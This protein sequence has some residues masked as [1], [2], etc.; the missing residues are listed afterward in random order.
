METLTSLEM[1]GKS[2]LAVNLHTCNRLFPLPQEPAVGNPQPC[3]P[4]FDKGSPQEHC[5]L[6]CGCRA[7]FRSHLFLM[8]N[9][10]RLAQ[11]SRTI[12]AHLFPASPQVCPQM[13]TSQ[14]CLA[15]TFLLKM[16]PLQFTPY[17]L[18]WLNCSPRHSAPSSTLQILLMGFSIISMFIHSLIE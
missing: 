11:V 15:L 12:P 1:Q 5:S 10:S 6:Q 2:L 3:C 13:P 18:S 17:S 4:L 9:G 8:G 14:G 7:I 16:V